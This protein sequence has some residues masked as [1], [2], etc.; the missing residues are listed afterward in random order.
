MEE[1]ADVVFDVGAHKGEDSSFYLRLG[2]R[3]VAVEANPALVEH[4]RARF[5][6]EITDGTYT[7]VGRAIGSADG[8]ISFF[9]NDDVSVWGTADPRWAL[10]NKHLGTESHEIKVPSVRFSELLKT[11][12]CP[13]YLKID[14]EGA[15]MLC[16]RDL[17]AIACRPKYL[18]LE[19]TKTSWSELVAEF[20]TLT[21]LGYKR[22]KVVDQT[23]HRTG[24]FKTR[25][26]EALSHSF[27]DGA[28]GPFGD[29]LPG[30][31]L[32]KSRAILRYVPI[33]L[34]YKAF[35]DENLWINRLV[36]RFPVLRGVIPE[37]HWYD[38]HAMRE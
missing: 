33:F 2:Y 26:D 12:G 35:G 10:R 29:D 37:A 23:R 18:S 3:V 14:V 20:D 30:R 8:T 27:E 36:R 32:S 22:F 21:R 25:T 19:S 6:R 15:D 38:T 17:G 11:Y 28:S 13:Y 5:R 4:L 24:V 9:V 1:L 31:W 7:L 16:V 34:A